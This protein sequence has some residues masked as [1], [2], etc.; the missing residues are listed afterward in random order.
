MSAE[1]C[2]TLH[3]KMI[4]KMSDFKVMTKEDIQTLGLPVGEQ[5]RLRVSIRTVL[6]KDRFEKQGHEIKCI[7]KAKLQ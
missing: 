4:R 6:E 1:T 2:S 7:V 3:R 5:I